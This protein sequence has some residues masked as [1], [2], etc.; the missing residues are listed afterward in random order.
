MIHDAGTTVSASVLNSHVLL[1]GPSTSSGR[2]LVT[3]PVR[4]APTGA[5]SSHSQTRKFD[6][7]RFEQLP[8]ADGCVVA[9][10]VGG[11]RDYGIADHA[12]EPGET[13]RGEDRMQTGLDPLRLV[14]GRYRD[15]DVDRAGQ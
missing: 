3:R 15:E 5:S 9:A 6:V 8:R 11:D 13:D 2:E 4:T 12:L 1:I 7:G 10:T 14:A